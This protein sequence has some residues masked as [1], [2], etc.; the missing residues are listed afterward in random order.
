[1]SR[2]AALAVHQTTG[3]LRALQ[4]LSGTFITCMTVLCMAQC[5][6]VHKVAVVS[7]TSLALVEC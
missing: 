5:H 7:A 1:V 2:A 3:L 4:Q 6:V